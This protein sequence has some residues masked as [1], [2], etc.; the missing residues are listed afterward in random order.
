MH[1]TKKKRLVFSTL[2]SFFPTHN[3]HHRHLVIL[4]SLSSSQSHRSGGR[5][6][7]QLLFT[8]RSQKERCSFST[9][10]LCI[11]L[12]TDTPWSCQLTSVSCSPTLP[13]GT[14]TQFG[15]R[16]ESCC[17]CPPVCRLHL[18]LLRF[19]CV[20]FFLLSMS[21]ISASESSVSPAVQPSFSQITH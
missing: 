1:L 17:W 2:S 7:G 4:H 20:G 10:T 19:L 12:F 6:Q 5:R 9:H 13:T 14:R 11:H 16:V 18:L 3:N 21:L 15:R 8:V